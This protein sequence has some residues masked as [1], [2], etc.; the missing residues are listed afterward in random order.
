MKPNPRT[1]ASQRS[2]AEREHSLGLTPRAVLMKGAPEHVNATIDRWHRDVLAAAFPE[3]SRIAGRLLDVGWGSGRLAVEMKARGVRDVVGVDFLPA[4][5]QH[6]SQGY[7]PAVCADLE[8]LPFGDSSFAGAYAIT[9]LMYLDD[10]RARKALVSIDRCVAPGGRIVLLEPGAEFN[11]LVRA[12][13][14]RRESDAL[15]RP[16]FGRSEFLRLAPARWRLVGTGSNRWMTLLFPLL[17]VAARMPR[18]YACIERIALK[19]DRPHMGTI[20]ARG[21]LSIYRWAVYET[22]AADSA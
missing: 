8:H 13:L 6:F 2:W 7:G 11:R 20:R 9:S 14:G 1:N 17:T 16:G 4:F 12:L 3:A 18:L 19:L 15:T 22:A 5:C 10:A 21:R